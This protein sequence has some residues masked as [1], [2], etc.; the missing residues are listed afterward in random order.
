MDT[1]S[2]Y[3]NKYLTAHGKSELMKDY[4]KLCFEE[5]MLHKLKLSDKPQQIFNCDETGISNH[6]TTREKAYGIRGGQHYQKKVC[7]LMIS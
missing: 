6:V 1:L 7:V 4:L 3:V 2:A 5:Q